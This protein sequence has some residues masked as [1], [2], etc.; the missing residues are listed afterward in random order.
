MIGQAG[1]LRAKLSPPQPY[2]RTLVRPRVLAV[3]SRALNHRLTVVQA[4]AG[5]GKTTALASLWR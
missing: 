2:R 4:G 3:L 5:Y 1:L